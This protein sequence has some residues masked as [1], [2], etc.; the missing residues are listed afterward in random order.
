M[1]AADE[2]LKLPMRL[3]L[4]PNCYVVVS[5]TGSVDIILARRMTNLS[6]LSRQVAKPMDVP[7]FREVGQASRSG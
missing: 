1:F 2:I 3:I 7:H 4:G 6:T 5:G